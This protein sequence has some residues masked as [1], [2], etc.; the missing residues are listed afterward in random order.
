MKFFCKI[1]LII[2]LAVS[3][4]LLWASPDNPQIGVDYLVPENPQPTT[5]G[6]KIEVIE[7]FGYF[8]SHCY[9]FESKL[10]KWAEKNKNK[11][12]FKR[13]HVNYGET[14]ARQQRIYYTL[15]AMNKLSSSMQDKVFNAVQIRRTRLDNETRIADFVEKHQI[16]RQKFLDMYQSFSVQTLCDEAN[17]LQTVYQ[18]EGVPVFIIDGRYMTSLGIVSEGNSFIRTEEQAQDMTIQVMDKLVSRALKE[19]GKK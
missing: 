19:R 2:G 14:T 4:N 1:F 17:Q 16:D 3:S 8:C 10:V 5:T 18:I 9:S 7:F 15:S 13:V 11:I 12:V 6:K